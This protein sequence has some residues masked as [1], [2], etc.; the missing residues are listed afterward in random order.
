MSAATQPLTCDEVREILAVQ[1]LEG[2]LAVEVPGVDEHVASCDG[3]HQARRDYLEVTGLLAFGLPAAPAS[4]AVRERLRQRL[5]VSPSRPRRRWV[6]PAAVAA[7]FV[8]TLTLGVL[9]GAMLLGGDDDAPLVADPARSERFVLRGDEAAQEGSWA[10]VFV[11]YESGA[12]MMR[13]YGL[14]PLTEGKVYQFWFLR[15][16][17]T[18]L[19]ADIFWP[20]AEG[21]AVHVMAL[22]PD[23]SVIRGMWVTLEPAPRSAV[24]EGPNVLV[25]WWE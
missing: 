21:N 2:H 19:D 6:W 14:P 10:E 4:P 8:L 12:A 3:C 11:D 24:P 1:A 18:R 9:L 25:T 22:P 23:W 15:D 5:S 20:T 17:G 13:A 16:D 7:G